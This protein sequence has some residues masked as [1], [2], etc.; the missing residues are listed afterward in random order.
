MFWHFFGPKGEVGLQAF[1]LGVD[2]LEGSPAE[3]GG[4]KPTIQ[5]NLHLII[6]RCER[7]KG[8]DETRFPTSSI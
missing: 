2:R 6:R 1:S 5:P 8:A 4:K 3:S 7:F